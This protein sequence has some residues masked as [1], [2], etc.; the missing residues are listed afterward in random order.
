[1]QNAALAVNSEKANLQSAKKP[2]FSIAIC[3]IPRLISC[4]NIQRLARL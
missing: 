1:M 4:I 3:K 2:R